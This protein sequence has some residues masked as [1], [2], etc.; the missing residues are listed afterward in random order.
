MAAP[1]SAFEGARKHVTVLAAHLEG[2]TELL[3]GRDPEDARRLLDPVLQCM[4]DAVRFFE[5]TVSQ[6]TGDGITV[7]FGAPLA[8]EDH[9]VRACF[10]ALRMQEMVKQHA[11]SVGRGADVLVQARIGLDSGQVVVRDIGSGPHTPY[12][13]VGRTTHLASRLAELAAPGSVLATADTQ[14]LAAGYVRVKPLGPMAVKGFGEPVEAYEVTGRG[15]IR[16]PLQAA[17]ARGFSRFVGRDAELAQLQRAVAQA[18][19]GRGQVAAIVGEP[20]V[21]KSRLVFE[22]MCSQRGEGWLVLE[23]RP[24]SYGKATSYLPVIDLLRGYFGVGDRDTHRDILER[25][26]ARILALDR[27][28]ESTLPALLALLDVP[29]EDPAWRGLEPSQRRHRTL[30]AVTRLVLRETQVQPL[31][32]VI[33]DLQWIDTETQA[34]L[35]G[36][37]ERLP[38]APLLLVVDYRPEYRHAWGS[39]MYYSQLRLDPLAPESAGEL[40][41]ALLGPGASLTPFKALL[42]ARTEGNPLFLEESVR[43]LVETQV[44]LGD[45]GAYRLAQPVDTIQV[46]ATVQTT[47]AWRIDRLPPDAKRLLETAAV[48]GKDVPFALLRAIAEETEETLHRQLSHL[49]TAELLYETRLSSDIGFTFK[50]AL[51][52]EVTYGSLLQDH[53]R[54]LHARIVDAIETLHRDRLGEQIERLAHHAVRAEL[55]EKAVS[56]LRQAGV[57]ALARS[58]PHEA[59]AWCEQALGVLDALPESPSTL[60][61][62]FEIRLELRPA[63][64]GLGELRGALKRLR[65]AEALAEKLDDDRRRG[66]VFAVLTNARSHLG[67]LDEALAT[68]TRALEIAGRLGD[69]R[70]RLVTTTYLEQAHVFRGDYER[71][72]ELAT[73]NLA[74]LPADS[75]YEAFGA[76][77]PISIYDRCRLIQSLAWLGR[78]AEAARHEAEALR[79]AEATHRA[80]TV[81]MVREAA[82]WCRLL[83]GDWAKARSLNEQWLALVRTANFVLDLP[84]AVASSAWALAQVG[85][86]GEALTRLHEGEQLLERHVARGYRGVLGWDY[87]SLGRAGLLLGRLDEAQRLGD[88]AVDFSPS[89]PGFAAHALDLLGDIAT[90][91][92]RFDAERGEAHYRKALALAT[93]RGMR[94]LVAHCH[95]GIGKLYRRTDKRESA[96]AHLTTARAMFREMDMPF[97]LEKA[98]AELNAGDPS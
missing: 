9:A 66:R 86:A 36:L 27:A 81:G 35:D 87:C 71:V 69:L 54:A 80:Y 20:G 64:V 8:H 76:A 5:G 73:D 23:A 43:A 72:V 57:R 44:L 1:K 90:H 14:R 96:H 98:A 74:A 28:L 12:M 7:L 50:H 59:R 75:V 78:F 93:P 95:F 19:K 62:G 84:S 2:P 70:L 34:F 42:A 58:A 82:C 18:E 15:E 61:Q 48:I 53:R 91:P 25:V 31:L 55:R 21:G 47:L 40:L 30:D 77:L 17:A 67:E 26:T 88:R 92:S 22:L 46:P 52:H 11:D 60:E 51:T 83:K 16:S 29:F 37:V 6:V 85:E 63:L 41:D 94:P 56:Y 3:A 89:H 68:G 13:A 39:K 33:E 49:R 4:L 45:P 32:V 38:T 65:E 24:A 97:W 79:L 10:A